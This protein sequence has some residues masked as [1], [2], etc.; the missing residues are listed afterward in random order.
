MRV[1]SSPLDARNP[2]ARQIDPICVPLQMSAQKRI[3]DHIGGYHLSSDAPM[4]YRA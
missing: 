3:A 4:N 2:T 1:R